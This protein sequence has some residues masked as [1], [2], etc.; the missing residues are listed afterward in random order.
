MLDFNAGKCVVLKIRKRHKYAYTLNGVVLK[1]VD[2]Q[3]DL[4]IHVLNTLIPNKQVNEICKKGNQRI[5]LIRRCFTDL[6]PPKIKNL[7]TVTVRSLLEY[8]APAWNPF[9]KQDIDKLESVQRRCL[10]LASQEIV[11]PTL[12]ERRKEMDL[13][14]TYKYITNRYITPPKTYFES[15]QLQ[16]RGHTRKLQKKYSK[17][18]VRKNFFSNRVVDDWNELPDSTVVAPSLATFSKKLWCNVA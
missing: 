2:S 7:Y 9:H 16:L 11:M 13:K 6:T 10:N 15:A 14:E 17:G 1:E 4:D 5:G 18:E 3:K 8:C 12:A